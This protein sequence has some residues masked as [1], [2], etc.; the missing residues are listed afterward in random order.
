MAYRVAN[1]IPASS[2]F[3]ASLL[4]IKDGQGGYLTETRNGSYIYDGNPSRFHE[5][6]FGAKNIESDCQSLRRRWRREKREI[7]RENINQEC[8]NE[9]KR[10]T[11]REHDSEMEREE[12]EK[13]RS[14]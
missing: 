2:S 11:M 3:V 13:K 10:K 4:F 5:W 14:Q 9:V 12:H 1:G 6:E 8:D 7:V